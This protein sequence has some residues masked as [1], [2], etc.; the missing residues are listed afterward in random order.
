MQSH[1]T[2]V[3]LV[4]PADVSTNDDLDYDLDSIGV[5]ASMRKGLEAVTVAKTTSAG[6]PKANDDTVTIVDDDLH[7]DEGA[8]GFAAGDI[9]WIDL[10]RGV[11]KCVA[12]AG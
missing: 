1:I 7:I 4:A 11:D 3:K 9:W 8:T 10:M 12:T 6:V 5:D 2:R